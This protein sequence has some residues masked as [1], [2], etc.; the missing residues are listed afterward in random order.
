VV[1]ALIVLTVAGGWAYD[2]R[3]EY[4]IAYSQLFGELSD[5]YELRQGCSAAAGVHDETAA[6]CH[7]EGTCVAPDELAA[8]LPV[9]APK[10][11]TAAF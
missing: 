11:A 1:T 2:H 9:E 4:G 6:C 5:S 10:P 7:G 3:V 8:L